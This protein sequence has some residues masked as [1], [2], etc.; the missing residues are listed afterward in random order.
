MHWKIH[1]KNISRIR[2]GSHM[3]NTTRVISTVYKRSK[4]ISYFH[5]IIDKTV[6][7]VSTFDVFIGSLPSPLIQC[8]TKLN[9]F[10]GKLWCYLLTLNRGKGAI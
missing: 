2:N 6:G 8:R 1:Y 7:K 3:L 4:Q 5:T 10:T 9:G